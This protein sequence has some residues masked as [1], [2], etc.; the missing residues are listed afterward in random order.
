MNKNDVW[1]ALILAI[2]TCICVGLI[3]DCAKTSDLTRPVIY[4]LDQK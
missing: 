4:N 1:I 2:A 3:T